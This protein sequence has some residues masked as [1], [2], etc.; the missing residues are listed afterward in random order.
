MPYV[1]CPKCKHQSKGDEQFC[2][3]CGTKL[4]SVSVFCKGCGHELNTG[5]RF[6]GKCGTRVKSIFWWIIAVI[7]TAFLAIFISVK[8]TEYAAKQHEL[9]GGGMN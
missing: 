6:C 8:M 9:H 4:E 3:R 1:I 5:D 7:L 2:S